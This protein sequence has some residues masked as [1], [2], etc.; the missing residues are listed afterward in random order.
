QNKRVE[1]SAE[2]TYDAIYRLI[3][4]T[5]REHLGQVG[6]AANAPT[7]HSYNDAPRVD[8]LHPNDGNAIGRY[9]ERYVY[10]AVGNFLKMRH[11]GTDPV[12]PTHPCWT[13]TY[14]YNEP[15][16]LEPG[17]QS[18][19]LSTTQV[20]NGTTAAPELYAYDAHGNMLRMPHLQVMQWDFKDQ[21]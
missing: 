6:G 5:G 1:P 21:L 19:R 12:H 18:N 10:D 4:A 15:S 3:E 13:R 17:K 11:C 14:A 16:Q 9:L 8:V 2:Y 7:T 20:G